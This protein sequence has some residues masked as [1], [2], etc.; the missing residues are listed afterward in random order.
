MLGGLFKKKNKE[1]VFWDW[2]SKHSDEY[3][4]L[5]SNQQQ[6]FADL[7]TQL[8]VIDPNLV[9]EFSTPLE[10]GTKEF[11]ISADG[12]QDSFHAVTNLVKHAPPFKQWK[13]IA[14]RQPHPNI[15]TVSYQSL[16]VNLNDVFFRYVKDHGKI[17]LELHLKGFYES[18]EWTAISFILVDTVLGEYDTETRLS[19]IEKKT[20]DE[21]HLHTLIPIKELP[22]ILREYKLEFSN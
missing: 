2:F 11:I 1:D 19:W 5:E 8:E 10:D 14:F 22:K 18:P 20:L 4:Q 21:E 17:G 13:V 6:L 15:S 12:I 16:T 9:F 3:F 7:K